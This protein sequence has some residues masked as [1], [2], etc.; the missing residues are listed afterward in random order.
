MCLGGAWGDP[1]DGALFIFLVNSADGMCSP[2]G[3]LSIH[4]TTLLGKILKTILG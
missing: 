4:L 2:A 3:F 1:V